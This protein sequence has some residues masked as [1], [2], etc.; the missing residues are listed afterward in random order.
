METSTD[1]ITNGF[2]ATLVEK[3]MDYGYHI[4][5]ESNTRTMIE[6]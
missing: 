6:M 4:Q 1:A 5:G 3:I 2:L